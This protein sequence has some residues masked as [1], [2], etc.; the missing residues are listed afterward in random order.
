MFTR[1]DYL[2]HRQYYA[3]F[4]NQA[5]KAK[6]SYLRERIKQSH[7]EHLNDIKLCTW[8]ALAQSLPRFCFERMR[9]LGDFMTQAGAVCILKEAAKQIKEQE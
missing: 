5:V 3:Q 9:E 4:V 2:G 8:D 1:K 6:V 7:D